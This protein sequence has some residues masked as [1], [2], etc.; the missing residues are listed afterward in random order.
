MDIGIHI[1]IHLS[2]MLGLQYQHYRIFCMDAS[3]KQLTK[4]SST[5]FKMYP[6]PF[7][8]FLWQWKE[9]QNPHLGSK[10]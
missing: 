9:A 4:L 8:I 6:S 2:P 1:D 10:K 7:I 3:F 5:I